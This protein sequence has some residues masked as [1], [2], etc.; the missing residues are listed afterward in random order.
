MVEQVP[1]PTHCPSMALPGATPME[2]FNFTSSLA[3]GLNLLFSLLKISFVCGR[4]PCQRFCVA[5]L[6]LRC[7]NN[8][9]AVVA[10]RCVEVPSLPSNHRGFLLILLPL[11]RS[12]NK[13]HLFRTRME[14]LA[15]I[16][17]NSNLFRVV[18]RDFTASL[19]R[20][21][22]TP[23]WQRRSN[24]FKTDKL[25]YTNIKSFLFILY[26]YS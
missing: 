10:S 22:R 16:C 24:S 21:S 3:S 1:S 7:T 2:C 6:R 14:I 23:E 18:E 8:L 4:A 17:I 15:G 11:Q 12:H 9:I 19:A 13:H 25:I 20:R 5:W 26:G